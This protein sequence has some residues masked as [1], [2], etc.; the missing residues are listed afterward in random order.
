M[1]TTLKTFT[2][3]ELDVLGGKARRAEYIAAKA[4]G[5]LIE[6]ALQISRVPRPSRSSSKA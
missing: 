4:E 1:D 3:D 5:K 2:F 6:P